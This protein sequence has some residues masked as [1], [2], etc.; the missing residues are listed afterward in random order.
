MNEGTTTHPDSGFSGDGE[1]VGR[2][3]TLTDR[4]IWAAVRDLP[5][6]NARRSM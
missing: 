6:T 1:R 5:S 4:Y 3:A 2:D